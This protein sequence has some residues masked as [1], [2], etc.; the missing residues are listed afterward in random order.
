M[1]RPREFDVDEALQTAME[2]FWR[3]GYEGTSL[4]DLTEGMGISLPP[5]GLAGAALAL[6]AIFLP[7]ALLVV[8]CLPFWQ[9]LRASPWARRALSGINAAVV[10]LL[11]AALYDPVFTEGVASASTMAVAAVSF[12]ALVSW[13]A[14]VWAVVAGAALAGA[15]AL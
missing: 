3:K 15:L 4:S 9:S 1:G 11:A 14:P 12:V 8:G 6:V 13:R 5:S 2:L 7:S 10:G